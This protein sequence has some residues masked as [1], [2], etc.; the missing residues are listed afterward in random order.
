MDLTAITAI[1][2]AAR[3]E[4]LQP[5]PNGVD[6]AGNGEHDTECQ[7][8]ECSYMLLCFPEYDSPI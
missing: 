4:G 8:D 6:C 5:S 3:A 1:L 7:C 2:E